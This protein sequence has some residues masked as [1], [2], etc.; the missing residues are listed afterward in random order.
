MS[1]KEALY[2][3]SARDGSARDGGTSCSRRMRAAML[4]TRVQTGTQ[5]QAHRHK[6]RT[7]PCGDGFL[8]PPCAPSPQRYSDHHR[9]SPRSP[10][11]SSQG[12]D[13]SPI[14][15]WHLQ[16]IAR[17]WPGESRQTPRPRGNHGSEHS[18]HSSPNPPAVHPH[19]ELPTVRDT[20]VNSFPSSASSMLIQCFSC[21]SSTLT[22]LLR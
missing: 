19:R 2:P 5:A 4:G 14:G 21:S 7:L 15:N 16:K 9:P 20:N 18:K 3:R 22:L 1:S 11:F 6:G 12:S 8:L 13:P 17:K 10:C